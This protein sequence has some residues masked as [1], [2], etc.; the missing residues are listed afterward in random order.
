MN[1][2]LVRI[3]YSSTRTIGALFA[4]GR[5]LCYTL[6]DPVRRGPKVPGATAIPAGTYAVSVA[7][8]PKRGV[9]VPWLHDVGGRQAWRCDC[10]GE[11]I[12]LHRNATSHAASWQRAP[13][14][15]EP[16]FRDVQIHPGNTVADTEG[17]ILVGWSRT[18]DTV[19]SSRLAFQEVMRAL[20][21]AT[22]PYWLR[23]VDTG[24][25]LV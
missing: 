9:P 16:N 17:C 7:L 1:L 18:E 22:S 21:W 12:F 3:D 10:C 5:W 13:E 2:L 15:D 25:P 4:A 8:S 11:V 20:E 14:L 6:E 19:Q 23:V 24:A